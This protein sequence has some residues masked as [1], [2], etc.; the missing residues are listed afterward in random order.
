MAQPP[1]ETT[2]GDARGGDDELD[3]RLARIERSVNDL[4]ARLG[5]VERHLDASSRRAPQIETRP[6]GQGA[7]PTPD[8]RT[9]AGAQTR[10]GVWLDATEEASHDASHARSHAA[11]GARSSAE[12]QARGAA[13]D[14]SPAVEDFP[15]GA[16]HARV[17]DAGGRGSSASSSRQ[18]PQASAVARARR[19]FESLVGGSW[20]NWLGIVAVTLGVGF[21]LKYAFE[22]QWIGPAGRVLLGGAAGCAILALAE[23]LRA[24]GYRAYAHV[25]TGGGIL[26]LYLSVYAARGLYNLIGVTPAF[27]LMSAVTATAVVLAVRYDARA[28]AVL[29]LI[30]GFMTPVLLKSDVDRQI[31]LFTY[32]AFLDAGV[33]AIAYFKRWR[34]LDHLAFAATALLFAGWWLSHYEP[35]KLWRTLLFLTLYFLMFSALAVVHNVLRKRRANGLDLSLVIFNATLY[36]STA[37]ALLEDAHRGALGAFALLVA[38]FY[39]L[40]AY[41]AYARHREDRLLSSAYVGAAATFLAVAVAVQFQQHWVTIGWAAEALALTWLGLRTSERAPRYFA[42]VAFYFAAVRWLTTDLPAVSIGADTHFVPL[43]NTRALSCL[44]VLAALSCATWLYRRAPARVGETEAAVITA[45]LTL[46]RAALVLVL[47]SADANDYFVQR[48]ARAPDATRDALRLRLEDTKQLTLSVVWTTYAAGFAAVGVARRLKSLRFAGLLWLAVTALKILAVDSASYDA[49][50]H[51]PVFNQTFAA[52]AVFVAAAWYVAHVYAR[53]ERMGAVERRAV[54]TALTLAGNLFAVAALSLEASGYFRKQL[55]AR[56]AAGL[57]ARDLRLARQLSL[58]LVW[59]VYGGAML[60]FGHAR[61]NKTLRLMALALLAATTI[62]VFFFDLSELEKFYRIV[63]FIV[64]GLVLLAVS[65]LYQQRRA[66]EAE[67]ET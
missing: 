33:L 66:R 53:D 35:W 9:S 11:T 1:E 2:A 46:T 15:F 52:F 14:E 17:E 7:S 24:R 67:G 48:V 32:V 19:D 38:A 43:L 54:V 64:L 61:A 18:P 37:Y 10:P 57:E 65:F 27:A 12:S 58:S 41:V 56:A 62:K 60:F 4:S 51:A 22:N 3:A 42:L 55:A 31:A 36:F 50:W 40:L 21:F 6:F 45:A 49:G 59:A 23:R 28:I 20:F 13:V 26:I 63:S 29:A 8:A 47:L 5:E 34:V 25:L 30:G 16:S 44:A 39:A